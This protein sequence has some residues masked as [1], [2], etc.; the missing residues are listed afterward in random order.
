MFCHDGF[1]VVCTDL[2]CVVFVLDYLSAEFSTVNTG[3][4]RLM[5]WKDLNRLSRKRVQTNFQCSQVNSE[6][7]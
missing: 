2:L 3:L 6:T 4:G 5:F 7:R 1:D